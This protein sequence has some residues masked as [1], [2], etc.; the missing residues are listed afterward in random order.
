MFAALTVVSRAHHQA[1]GF[2]QA[3]AFG[4][5]RHPRLINRSACNRADTWLS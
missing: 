1:S 2:D 4:R 5:A 3:S